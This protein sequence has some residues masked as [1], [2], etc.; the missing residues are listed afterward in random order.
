MLRRVILL[1]AMLAAMVPVRT[2]LVRADED[3]RTAIEF[4]QALR[5]RGYFDLASEYLE[6]LR[7]ERG[8]PEEVRAVIDYEF[9]RLL[10]D[11][12]S[13][14]GDLVRRKELLEQSRSRLETFTKAH[15]NHELASEALV[16][17]A[18]LLVERG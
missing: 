18:R 7:G 16:Q 9:G 2:G 5:E 4:E 15:P 14:T 10:T 13:K 3:P 8:T 17:L 11:E 12:A 6:K 1:V